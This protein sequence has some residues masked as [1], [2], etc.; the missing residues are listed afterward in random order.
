MVNQHNYPIKM[1]NKEVLANIQLGQSDFVYRSPSKKP[2]QGLLKLLHDSP[3]QKFSI[4]STQTVQCGDEALTQS[5]TYTGTVKSFCNGIRNGIS[6]FFQNTIQNGES[7]EADDKGKIG[8]I[9]WISNFGQKVTTNL[10]PNPRVEEIIEPQNLSSRF[11]EQ[12]DSTTVKPGKKRS[13]KE[14]MEEIRKGTLNGKSLD[15]WGLKKF[16]CTENKEPEE[17]DGKPENVVPNSPDEGGFVP[18]TEVH[19]LAFS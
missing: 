11:E 13:G 12:A 18:G 3:D 8:L 4:T 5:T 14:I 9:S 2:G 19:T 16:R 10:E 1:S 17:N 7:I 15:H 6:S